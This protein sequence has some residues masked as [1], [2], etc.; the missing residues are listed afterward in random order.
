[1]AQKC[2]HISARLRI[3]EI[4]EGELRAAWQWSMS[5]E[6]LAEMAAC[7]AIIENNGRRAYR[8]MSQRPY[9]AALFHRE[10]S[11]VS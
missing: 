10:S 8:E 11:R 9:R 7:A 5:T 3:G 6:A 2:L 4:V 1:M